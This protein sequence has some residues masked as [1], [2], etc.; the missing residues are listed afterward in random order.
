MGKSL[1]RK[2]ESYDLRT[3][4][5]ISACDENWLIEKFGA[6]GHRLKLFSN[7]LDERVVETASKAKSISAETTFDNDVNDMETLDKSLWMLCDKISGRLKKAGLSCRAVTLKLR[8]AN[9]QLITRSKQ[10]PF[11]TYLSEDIYQALHL[12]LKKETDGRFFRLIGAGAQK[13]GPMENAETGDL[14]DT[15]H[16]ERMKI[17]NAI[18]QV[19]AKFGS[20]IIGKGRGWT[21][22]K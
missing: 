6:I 1:Q 14:L 10:L 22:R 9:F 13:L 19:R 18:D 7:G 12:L 3:I 5:Q 8:F 11:P 21:G 2:L 15:G 4:G 16:Q 17:E 20:G